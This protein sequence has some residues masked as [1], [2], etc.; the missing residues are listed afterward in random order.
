M[1]ALLSLNREKEKE[2]EKKDDAAHRQ[3]QHKEHF[4]QIVYKSFKL[5]RDLKQSANHIDE[6]RKMNR[7]MN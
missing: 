3:C 6:I 7:L 5:N 1:F 2:R 4:N